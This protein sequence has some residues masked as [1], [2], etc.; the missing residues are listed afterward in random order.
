M[1]GRSPRTGNVAKVQ[2]QR[3]LERRIE[4]KPGLRILDV[5]G[6]GP[7]PFD[8]WEP[9]F[10]VGDFCLT[11]IDVSG[12]EHA[13]LVA[14]R[15]GWKTALVSGSGYALES[16]FDPGS[17]DLVVATQ[18]LEHVARLDRF[19]GQIAHVLVRGGETFFTFDSAHWR[20]RWSVRWPR[21]LLRNVVKAALARAGRERY[22]DLPWRSEEVVEA[23][24]AR[25]LDVVEVRYHNLPAIKAIHNHLTPEPDKDA[26]MERWLALEEE[27]NRSPQVAHRARD[28][29]AGVYIHA[30]KS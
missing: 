26:L 2:V 14:E 24:R 28:L 10:P 17:F 18:V 21:R 27:I 6:I 30:R 20:P 7:R 16:F 13:R 8:L 25:A 23:C 11:V 1:D 9:L 12:V 19:M 29:F 15:Q 3:Q 22:Y 5:G 4:S